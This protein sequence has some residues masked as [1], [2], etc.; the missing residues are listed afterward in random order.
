MFASVP[1]LMKRCESLV[2]SREKLKS[3]LIFI[4]ENIAKEL[5]D[6]EKFKEDRMGLLLDYNVRLADLQHSYS[7]DYVKT[8]E[9]K[10][11][12]DNIEEK[13]IEKG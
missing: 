3:Q 8:M 9:K 10:R 5:V 1:E 6:L 13:K 11:Y 4:N 7:Q 12:M 2:A